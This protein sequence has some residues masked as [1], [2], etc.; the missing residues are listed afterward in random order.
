MSRFQGVVVAVCAGL[1][2]SCHATWA[3]GDKVHSVGTGLKIE[4]ELKADDPKVK[5]TVDGKTH[6]LTGKPYQVK[7]T[8]GKIYT[9]TMDSAQFDSFLVLQDK[10]GKQLFLDD[11]GGGKLNS[12]LVFYCDKDDTYKIHAAALT[13]LGAFVLKVAESKDKVLTVEQDGI[14]RDGKLT[15]DTKSGVYAVAMEEGKTYEIRLNS[16]DFDSFL[17]LKDTKGK[18]LAHDDDSGGG[19]NSKLEF[20]AP[21][22]GVYVIIATSLGMQG[23]GD[24]D[25]TITRKP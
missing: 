9:I 19:L 24:Y 11:D 3:G 17:F 15:G 7:M 1:L 5:V 8:G 20:R 10:A 22:T 23:S 18:Q 4:G 25:L 21:A 2:L 12:R 6:E 14:K 16:K 13:G